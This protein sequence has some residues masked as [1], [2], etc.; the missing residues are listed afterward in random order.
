MDGHVH[1]VKVVFVHDLV[2]FFKPCPAQI[3]LLHRDGRDAL[4]FVEATEE[5]FLSCSFI[6]HFKRAQLTLPFVLHLKA[7]DGP[8][9]LRVG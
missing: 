3:P 8:F 7:I 5:D 6:N 9:Q 2:G 4:G 1:F